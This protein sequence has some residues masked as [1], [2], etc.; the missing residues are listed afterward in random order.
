MACYHK[1][2]TTS[3]CI[4]YRAELSRVSDESF[5]NQKGGCHELN[6]RYFQIKKRILEIK[7]D[8]GEFITSSLCVQYEL[9]RRQPRVLSESTA[10]FSEI[11]V[12]VVLFVLET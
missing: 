6:P 9:L 4:A 2:T 12:K 5:A 3:F 11:D 7:V 10:S 8:C 1:I